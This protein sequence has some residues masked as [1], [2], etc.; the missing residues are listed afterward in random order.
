VRDGTE[1]VRA[2]H[3]QERLDKFAAGHVF[4][5]V[6]FT[7]TNAHFGCS[8]ENSSQ[9][10]HGSHAYNANFAHASNGLICVD[11]LVDG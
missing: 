7:Q 11:G 5:T 8:C 2:D 3:V 9:L 10:L 4:E 6:H 1:G